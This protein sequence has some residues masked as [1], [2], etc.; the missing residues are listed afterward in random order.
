MT[1][2]RI[3][4]KTFAKPIYRFLMNPVKNP[5]KT[6][7]TILSRILRLNKD[8]QFGKIHKFR[9]IN[10]IRQF[11]ELLSPQ[12]YEYFRP[13]IESMTKGNQDILI[14]GSPV[15]WGSTAGSTGP[16]K[17]IP[18][19]PQSLANALRGTL[20]IYLSYI[21]EN[22][23]EH[24]KFLDGVVCFFSADPSL[25][26]IENIPVGF[27]TGVFSQYTQ[28]RLWSPLIR[29]LTY[30]T[31]HLY[32]VKDIQKRYRILTE[33]LTQ[34]DVRAFSGVT[35]VVLSLL[36]VI[37][38]Y[39]QQKNRKLKYI[40]ELFPNYQF[41][42]LGGESPKFYEQR[43]FELIGRRVDY[44]EVYGAT[45]EIIGAQLQH[46]PGF[47]PILDANFLEFL[48]LD[49]SERLLIH[50]VK[51]NVEYKVIITNFNGLYAY[52]LGDIIKFIKTD[53]ALFIF[54]HR[55][56]TINLASE[57][58]TTQQISDA[59]TLTTHQ[60]N[61]GITEYCV[62]GKYAPRPHYIF[63]IEFFQ[64]LGPVNERQFLQSL[65][66]NLM[67]INPVYHA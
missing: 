56:G 44:R 43:L 10:S 28:N 39:S 32:T 24:S 46:T 55:E 15:F 53:P 17:L 7:A 41:S 31:G 37:L 51:K 50:E 26:K 29:N 2:I 52:V 35:S 1:I 58:M 45:E 6:Q 62:V 60:H 59:L 18:I 67:R 19:S 48:T 3:A 13:Y 38:K 47:T 4:G 49:S 22:P 16:S 11:Q 14:P 9:H 27:G 40:E 21:M 42:I 20:R 65:N 33:E 34:K 25:K 5:L 61:C 54:S 57:K 23:K 64:N 66:E 63:I 12:Y 30:T 36:E 8:T